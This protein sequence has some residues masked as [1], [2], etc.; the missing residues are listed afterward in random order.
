M[1]GHDGLALFG[2]M[3]V[4]DS[5]WLYVTVP[6]IFGVTFLQTQDENLVMEKK[7][8]WVL[9]GILFVVLGLIWSALYLDYTPVGAAEIR[10][11]Q[12]RYYYPLMPL[13]MLLC[14]NRRCR[15][16]LERSCYRRLVVG[17]PILLQMAGMFRNFFVR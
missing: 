15:I 17:V 14:S 13:L 3:G 6:W 5:R 4:L 9:A 10:G 16:V 11:V 8:K 1:P 12:P 2:R 7:Y